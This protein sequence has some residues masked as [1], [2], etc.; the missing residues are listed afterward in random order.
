MIAVA[1]VDSAAPE[2][3]FDAILDAAETLLE[4][5]FC[6]SVAAETGYPAG[7]AGLCQIRVEGVVSR[8]QL[9][10]RSSFWMASAQQAH[11]SKDS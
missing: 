1:V 10:D 6:G 7:R 2:K 3:A 4:Y 9:E 8:Q 11:H 5:S